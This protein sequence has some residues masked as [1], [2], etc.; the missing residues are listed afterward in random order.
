M[1]QAKATKRTLIGKANS[2]IFI[3]AIIGAVSL[4]MAGVLGK[5]L[6]ER[7]SFQVRVIN[8]KK[9]ARDTLKSNLAE[10]DQLKTS[11]VALDQ[12][13]NN[14]QV[15]LDAL[16]SKYNFPAVASS[17][18]LLAQRS[19]QDMT[20]FKFSGAD[21]GDK[22]EKESDNPKPVEIPFTVSLKGSTPK[23]VE[24]LKDLERSIRPFDIN[25]L[26]M[27]GA[28]GGAVEVSLKAVTFYQPS[29]NLETRTKEIK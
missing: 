9:K 29:K 1:A 5:I 3:A 28:D 14:S 24:F 7:H 11:L 10:L 23:A 8:E 22:P 17:V 20:N 26:T 18:E 6:W 4:S 15:I 2:A 13:A 27:K 19:G 25:E 12:T 21:Q 16:P